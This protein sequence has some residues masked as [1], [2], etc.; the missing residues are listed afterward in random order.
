[1]SAEDLIGATSLAM[2]FIAWL[3]SFVMVIVAAGKAG[4]STGSWG[5]LSLILSPWLAALLLLFWAGKSEKARTR[6]WGPGKV[7][8]FLS[9]GLAVS[10]ASIVGAFAVPMT[11]GGGFT[12]ADIANVK[13]SIK[14]NFEEQNGNYHVTGI[15]MIRESRTR[16][17]GLVTVTVDDT[18]YITKTCDAI[19]GDGKYIW[20]CQ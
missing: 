11:L 3:T 1:M 17:T 9:I 19:Y 10:A 12:D 8:G 18:T 14:Q 7:R 5:F 20:H 4:Q 15:E 13:K 2:L 16:L 6:T